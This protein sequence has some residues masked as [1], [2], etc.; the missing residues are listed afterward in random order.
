VGTY[1]LTLTASNGVGPDATQGFTLTIDDRTAPVL[2]SFTRQNPAA[3]P[4]NADTLVFRATF[5]EDVQ[6][7]NAGDFTVS[8][9]TATITNVSVVTNSVYDLTVSGGDLAGLDG[10]VDLNLSPAQDITDIAGNPLPSGEPTID[11]TYNVYNTGP[12]AATL[13]SPTGNIGTSTPTYTWDEVSGATWYYLWINDP[14]GNIFKQWYEGSA[15]C[16]S[17]SC[18]VVPAGLTLSAS[19]H[20][21][22]IQTWNS[23]GYGPWSDEMSFSPT[24]PAKTTLVSPTG[25]TSDTTPTYTWDEVSGATW[26]YLWVN[27]PSGNVIKQ[28]YDASVICSEGTCSVTPTTALVSGASY[29]WWI[30]TW[31]SAGYGLWS[32]SM[33]FTPFLLGK[34]TL[35]SPTGNIGTSTP[36]Y[37]WD[38]VS[39]ATWYYLWIN[40]PSGNIFKQWYEG[41][42]V[43]SSGSCSVVPA[44]LTLSASTHTWWIQTWNSVGYGPW[45]DEMSFSPTPPAKTT[46]V[47]PT[48]STSD[49][50]PTYTWDEVSGAT[51][52]YLWV[53]GPS[54]NVIKQWYDAS[55]ICSE[56]TCSVTPTTALVSGAHTWWVQ[57]YNTAGYGLWSDRMDFTLP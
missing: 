48:G 10:T 38:E 32:D 21:W 57:T 46:L 8:G 23:V 45:S 5:S 33:S 35:V 1:H 53:N 30:Q 34:A 13:V 39:G 22:W 7:V 4:T 16:S 25:S 27:G 14:S 28:W 56:G 37:T 9:T 54:G 52:Y 29:S 18:S 44:G 49:T 43:C 51:W 17:G 24:P 40:D 2:N 42:A 31:N 11:Q 12:G 36:T 6:N 50:T 15:V 26:Y 19:T 55:V 47:S 20:T 41:S 3:S